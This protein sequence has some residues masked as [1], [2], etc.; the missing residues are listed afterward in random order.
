MKCNNVYFQTRD[1]VEADLYYYG[2]VKSY[3]PWIFHRKE[4]EPSSNSDDNSSEAEEDDDDYDDMQEMIHE[5]YTTTTVNS[6][7]GRIP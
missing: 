1:D 6:W 5:N 4:F 2:I 3:T 7:V